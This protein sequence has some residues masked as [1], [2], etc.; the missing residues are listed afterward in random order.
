MAENNKPN[1]FPRPG[2]MFYNMAFNEKS[3]R[4]YIRLFRVF[5]KLVVP[6]YKLRILPLIGLGR[7][8]LVL[9]TKGRRSGKVRNNPLEYIRVNHKIYIFSA[10]GQ[11]SDWFKNM[12][13]RPDEVY[14]QVGFRKFPASFTVLEV[15]EQN[16]ILKWLAIKHPGYMKLGFGWNPNQ[17]N[18]ETVDFSSV[19][20]I[21]KIISIQERM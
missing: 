20:K 17:D 19:A 11:K 1:G 16:D 3:K 14:V 5:N 10:F 2:S 21:L 6:L 13:A 12:C 4:R 9:T 15:T 8:L 7:R 18:P